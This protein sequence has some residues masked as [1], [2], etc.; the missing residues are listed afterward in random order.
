MG[1]NF[2]DEDLKIE[3]KEQAASRRSDQF[4]ISYVWDVYA[5]AKQKYLKKYASRI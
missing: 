5:K 1:G 4:F 2:I 3:E